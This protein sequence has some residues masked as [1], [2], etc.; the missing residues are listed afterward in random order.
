MKRRFIAVVLFVAL[1]LST[2]LIGVPAAS[3]LGWFSLTADPQHKQAGEDFTVNITTKGL[4]STD[5]ERGYLVR[6]YAVIPGLNSTDINFSGANIPA[7]VTDPTERSYVEAQDGDLVLAWGPSGGFP[8]GTYETEYESWEG[9]TTDFTANITQPGNYNVHFVFYNLTERQPIGDGGT[10]VNI[11]GATTSWIN[12]TANN[13]TANV[14]EAFTVA[15]NSRGNVADDKGDLVRFYAWVQGLS[16]TDVTF[17]GPNIPDVFIPEWGDDGWLGLAWGPS[18]GFPLGTYETEYESPEGLTTEFVAAI[19]KAG[20]Y[21]VYFNLW[22]SAKNKD[23][24]W[25]QMT[26]TIKA[27][28]APAA[29]VGGGA[30]PAPTP[31]TYG[32]AEDTTLHTSRLT[33]LISNLSLIKD[34]LIGKKAKITLVSAAV[35]SL[36]GVKVQFFVDGKLKKT[37]KKAPFDYNLKIKSGTHKLS[38]K[39]F[40]SKGNLLEHIENT[41]T[42]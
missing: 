34:T 26:L 38:I 40:D 20:T 31:E 21:A 28:V 29:G 33:T 37:D 9:M 23:I 2:V 8:L 5:D 41:Y 24:G 39:I 42:K 16:T 30:A 19:S 32:W 7:V 10:W 18:S 27:P 13:V 11:Y 6:F 12:I 36:G 25:G 15:V 17:S 4:V 22:D 3:A 1:F 35:A 14:N